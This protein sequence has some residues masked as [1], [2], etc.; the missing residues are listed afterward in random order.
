MA[1]KTMEVETCDFCDEYRGVGS[2]SLCGN[3]ICSN[4]SI[5][6]KFKLLLDDR[7]TQVCPDC[8]AQPFGEVWSKLER[9]T[10]SNTVRK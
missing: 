2:C 10:S 8:Q 9:V 5:F 3:R 4:H 6:V 1:R 7:V